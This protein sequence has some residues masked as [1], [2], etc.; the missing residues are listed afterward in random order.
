MRVLLAIGIREGCLLGDNRSKPGTNATA[1]L[2][3]PGNTWLDVICMADGHGVASPRCS[4][5]RRVFNLS[6]HFSARTSCQ[7]NLAQHNFFWVPPIAPSA[8]RGTYPR[9]SPRAPPRSHISGAPQPLSLCRAKISAT[10]PDGTGRQFIKIFEAAR[11]QYLA[12]Q[13]DGKNSMR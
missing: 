11:P 3:T 2:G 5:R 13:V 10:R 1:V 6:L 8:A 12:G 9:S 7:Y 4:A